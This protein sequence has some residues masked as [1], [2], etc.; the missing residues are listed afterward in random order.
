MTDVGGRRRIL[1]VARACYQHMTGCPPAPHEL[2]ATASFT[3]PR[4]AR[5]E[6]EITIVQAGRQVAI[7]LL[8]RSAI[9][10]TRIAVSERSSGS[11][12]ARGRPIP[13]A[14][15]STTLYT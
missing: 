7:W 14:C 4:A 6:V 8:V 12:A 2:A 10:G 11:Q 5:T 13:T 15:V 9:S 3:S 1:W